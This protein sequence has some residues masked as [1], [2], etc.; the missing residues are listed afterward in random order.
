MRATPCATLYDVHTLDTV[1]PPSPSPHHQS[2]ATL[3]FLAAQR[4]LRLFPA[5][6]TLFSTAA[7][8]PASAAHAMVVSHRQRRLCR[9][10]AHQSVAEHGEGSA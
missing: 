2:H 8:P 9:L 7:P 10:L 3:S 1:P 5:H 4:R 6:A